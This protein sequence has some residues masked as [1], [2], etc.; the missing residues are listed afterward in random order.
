YIAAEVSSRLH[1]RVLLADEVGLGKT[2]EACLIL[3]RL[4]LTGRAQR[5]LIVVPDSLVHQWFVELLR[6]F[7]LW[8]HIFD[9]ERCEAIEAVNADTNPFEDDQL[10]LCSIS[11]FTRSEPRLQ[12]ALAAEWDLLV[13]DE[14]HHL[15]WAPDAVSPEYAVVE[16]IGSKTPG[17]LLLTATPEQLGRASHFARL[18]LLDPDRFF[19][20]NE[21]IGE[22]EHYREV[23][24]L[25]DKLLNRCPLAP[26]DAAL[27][28]R[29]LGETEENIR[30]RLEK[31]E[32]DDSGV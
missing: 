13:V 10:V 15:G 11:L 27:L 18:R 8:F 20:L 23:A 19:D 22:V 24:G 26:N 5:V 14:A 2:I 32:R 17:L 29:I 16:A 21:F 6:R 3:H 30:A 12:Q 31:L 25:A 28:G 9:E 4:I 1:P 7:N